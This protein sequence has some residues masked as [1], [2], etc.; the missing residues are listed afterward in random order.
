VIPLSI[1]KK[2]RLERIREQYDIRLIIAFG[3]RVSG[4][5]HESSDLD[6]GIL[7]E[8]GR[9]PLKIF[10]ELDRLFPDCEIDLA[11]LNRA[12]PLFLNE[13]NKNCQL[14]SGKLL[15]FQ[16]FRIYA[17]RRYQDFKPYLKMEAETN[18]RLLR[19]V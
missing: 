9:Y 11:N 8:T 15:D 17:F 16:L 18:L 19:S 13:I 14:L 3:S 7:L 6:I 2:Q 1:Q 12:D 5:T 4:V 10:I